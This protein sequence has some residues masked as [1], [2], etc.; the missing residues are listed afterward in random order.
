MPVFRHPTLLSAL[1]ALIACAGFGASIDF[2]IG[3]SGQTAI[4]DRLETWWLQLSYV[5]IRHFGK[6]EARYSADLLTRLFGRF[7]S[8]RRVIVSCAIYVNLFCIYAIIPILI[9][10][11]KWD[12]FEYALSPILLVEF[13]LYI[14]TFSLSVTITIQSTI[15]LARSLP[16]SP[17]LTFVIYLFALL[18]QYIF[19][20]FFPDLIS[21]LLLIFDNIFRY[22]YDPNAF[23]DFDRY[24]SVLISLIF[25]DFHIYPLWEVVVRPF[26]TIREAFYIIFAVT[27]RNIYS[28]SLAIQLARDSVYYLLLIC[29]DFALRVSLR[30]LSYSVR[31]YLLY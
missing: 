15:L 22:K 25:A 6:Y 17:A 9:H 21:R 12:S 1:S 23:S 8:R 29:C 27:A 3:K 4:R 20:C 26:Y 28:I 16:T 11:D 31:Y 30:Y 14:I 5:D 19:L 18:L 2:W 10:N 7:T 24:N 13:P